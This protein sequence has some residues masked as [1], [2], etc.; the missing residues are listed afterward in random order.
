MHANVQLRFCPEMGCQLPY[1]RLKESYRDVNGNVHSLV[2]LNIGF[3]PSLQPIQVKK[4]A[5]ALTKRF[6]NRSN[7]DYL[8]GNDFSGLTDDERAKALIY[9]ERMKSEGG[10]DR[11]DEREG[12]NCQE[13]EKYIDTDTIEHT[14]ARNVGAEWLCYQAIASLGLETFLLNKGWSPNAI[15]TAISSLI[16]R[17]VY[18]SSE[19]ASYSIMHDN[20]AACELVSGN[21]TW[22]PGYNA[23]YKIT[24]K[25][26][27]I[28]DELETHLCNKT[29]NLFNLKNQIMLFDLTN[30]YFEGR[31]AES[32]KAKFGRSKEKRYDCKLLVLALCINKEGFI[33][34]SE[35][36]EGNASDPKSLPSM[37]K[38]LAKKTSHS[39]EKCL[40]V[41]DAG[42]ATE[43]NLKLLK[44]NGFNYLCVSRT[45][46]KNYQLSSDQASV[47]VKDSRKREITLRQVHTA[48]DEDYFLE[49]TSPSKAMTEASMNRLFRKLFEEKM[50]S[51]NASLSKKGGTKTYEKVIERV[52]RAID[53]Y[54]SISRHYTIKYNKS[55]EKPENMESVEWELKNEEEL[56]RSEGVYFLRTNVK[57]FDEKTTWDYYNLIR[58]I[59]TTNRQLKTDLSLRPIYHQKDERSNAHLFLGLLSYW[60]VNTIRYR[61]KQSGIKCYWTEIVRRMSTQKLVTTEAINMLGEKVELRRCSRPSKQAMEIYNAMDYKEAPFKKRKICRS[62]T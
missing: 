28:K 50:K 62:Q 10:I 34:Y 43:D 14:D 29:D 26:Y 61:L 48:P 32:K 52:G 59:E 36:L 4:I 44:N 7:S 40:V 60:V 41:M 8:F 57:T 51:I 21:E 56:S 12:K 22:Y 23:I 11:F 39:S 18:S 33:R 49:I 38:E 46:L 19:N 15:K 30:F 53:K 3:E 25:L 37:V 2:V 5:Y 1:Y 58:E 31:K 9:W 27:K 20:S 47:V 24:D 55:E 42:I 16:V 6:K 45:K 35:V 13:A 54:P 17:T